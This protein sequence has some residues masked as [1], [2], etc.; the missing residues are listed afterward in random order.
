[1][2]PFLSLVCS[3]CG[4]LAKQGLAKYNL[5]LRSFWQLFSDCVPVFTLHVGNHYSVQLF[6]L[7]VPVSCTTASCIVFSLPEI[8]CP[9]HIPYP[10]FL[11][12]H[13]SLSPDLPSLTDKTFS[14]DVVATISGAFLTVIYDF[15]YLTSVLKVFCF[16]RTLFFIGLLHMIL[17]PPPRAAYACAS[18]HCV[19]HTGTYYQ[20][21]YLFLLW[22][23]KI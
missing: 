21:I 17:V 14:L 4:P 8:M 23:T 3:W 19:I 10:C 16:C 11:H 15:I 13:I 7:T 20:Y 5:D 18:L 9:I 2:I 6:R 1:M 12:S 22:A